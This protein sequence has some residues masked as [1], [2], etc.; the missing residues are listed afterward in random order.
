MNNPIRIEVAASILGITEKEIRMWV[1]YGYLVELKD[2]YV[3]RKDVF[4]M[5]EKVVLRAKSYTMWMALNGV[6]RDHKGRFVQSIDPT[7]Y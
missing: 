7:E 3:G 1:E 2:G 6:T 4:E 5:W